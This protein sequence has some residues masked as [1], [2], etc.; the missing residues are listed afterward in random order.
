MRG[1]QSLDLRAWTSE[2]VSALR[3]LLSLHHPSHRFD[4]LISP[5]LAELD[6][7]YNLWPD[8]SHEA[9]MSTTQRMQS[10]AFMSSNAVL[11]LA[12][13]CRWVMNSSTFSFPSM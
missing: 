11:I 2:P 1:S 9:L 7:T 13:G 8:R 12:R 4:M 10:P 5:I 3:G 6:S